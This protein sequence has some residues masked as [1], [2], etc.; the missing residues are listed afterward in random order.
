MVTLTTGPYGIH[1]SYVDTE[2]TYQLDVLDNYLFDTEA[3]SS[4]GQWYKLMRSSPIKL[5][6]HPI[7]TIITYAFLVSQ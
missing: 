2:Y 4:R 1:R 6:T 7:I 5:A 3:T